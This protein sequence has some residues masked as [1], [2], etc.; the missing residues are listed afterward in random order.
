MQWDWDG[1][2]FEVLHPPATATAKRHDNEQSCVLRISVGERHILLTADIETASEARLL[3]LH[4][5]KLPADLLVAPHHGSRSS[6]SPAFVAAVDPQHVIFTAGYRNR[7]PHPHPEVIRRYME[8]G[9]HILRSDRDGAITIDLDT[10][11]IKQDAYRH[12]HRRYWSPV[13]E[14]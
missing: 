6:S 14:N 8:Q 3:Q 10:S 5:D 1:V 12:S 11:G 13:P 4:P 9:S 2:N 7:F